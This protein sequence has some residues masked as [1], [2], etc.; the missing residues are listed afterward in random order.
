MEKSVMKRL[1]FSTAHFEKSAL[2]AAITLG[3]LS[4]FSS[5]YAG[6]KLVPPN[7]GTPLVIHG[8]VDDD[9]FAN[10]DPFVVEVFANAN[11]CLLLNVTFQEQDLEATLISPSGR[12]WTDDD[13][14]PGTQPLI[15]ALT[16]T[17]GWHIFTLSHFAGN[18]VVSDFA[19]S[20]QRLSPA[21]ASCAGP[22]PAVVSGLVQNSASAK[23]PIPTR[24]REQLELG[25][26]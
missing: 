18:A 7:G 2:A 24:S 16:N 9:S 12:I 22:T 25:D 15:K 19:V 6:S 11:E 13:G 23:E 26:Q 14:G 10:A 3:A 20:I 17:K 1:F 21:N 8:A 5:A 4:S